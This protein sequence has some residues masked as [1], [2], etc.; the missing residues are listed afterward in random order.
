MLHSEDQD[1]VQVIR[2]ASKNKTVHIA[3]YQDLSSGRRIV[4]W[5]DITIVFRDALYL[6]HGHNVLPFLKGAAFK[7]LEPLR[8]AAVPG[9]VLD[10]VL[11]DDLTQDGGS[12]QEKTQRTYLGTSARLY[13]DE[14]VVSISAATATV[15]KDPQYGEVAAAMENYTYMERPNLSARGPQLFSD[16]QSDRSEKEST[17]DIRSNDTTITDA[18][19]QLFTANVQ[20]ILRAEQPDYSEKSAEWLHESAE[21]GDAQAQFSL[22]LRYALGQGGVA[23]DYSAGM[24]WNI[25]SAKQGFAAAQLAAGVMYEKGTGVAKDQKAAAE[26]YLKAAEQEVTIAQV[27]IGTMYQTGNGVSLDYTAAMEWFL[28]AAERGNLDAMV[29]IGGTYRNGL[30][31]EQ[32]YSLAMEWYLKAA[33]Q[34]HAAAQ[35]NVAAMYA[36]GEG[37]TKN[38][39]TSVEWI[40]KSAEGGHPPSQY[41]LGQ[42]FADG[43]GVLQDFAKAMEWY[44]RAAEQGHADAQFKVGNIYANGLGVRRDYLKAIHWLSKAAKQGSSAAQFRLGCLYEDGLGMSKDRDK[45]KEL[46][47]KAAENGHEGAQRSIL[48]LDPPRIGA[49]PGAVLD[50]VV[51]GDLTQDAGA[52]QEQT[53]TEPLNTTQAIPP[54]AKE[55]PKYGEIE[56]AIENYTRMD[57]PTASARGRNPAYGLVE[58][59]MENYTHIDRPSFTARGPQQVSDANT[60]QS[61]NA[62][63]GQQLS[64]TKIPRAPQLLSATE[65]R[66]AEALAQAKLEEETARNSATFQSLNA[67]DP[68]AARNELAAAQLVKA[69]RCENGNS[70]VSQNYSL[71]AAWFLLAAENGNPEAQYFIGSYYEQGIG[72]SQDYTKASEW[73]FKSAKRRGLNSHAGLNM[74]RLMNKGLFVQPFDGDNGEDDDGDD[75]GEKISLGHHKSRSLSGAFR[76]LFAR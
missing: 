39:S 15:A 44:L 53:Q 60:D 65:L 7:E 43:Y 32:D 58:A 25:K 54:A 51:K 34:G 46:Y 74:S 33:E 73:Y 41:V 42:R 22:A 69:M 31:V 66:F 28:K 64:S 36:V 35:A 3:T 72:V 67:Q 48:S 30:G 23:H 55:D 29:S 27:A 57:P 13:Q 38:E 20:S 21:R 9:A 61:K 8:V 6:Q 2:L 49:I 56:R 50:V 76:K 12:Q 4:L 14:S 26:W 11:K 70:N 18:P 19:R 62:T 63:Q 59:A 1:G 16:T 10:I 5:S 47:L 24:T 37:V 40:R 68:K 17:G 71:A 52:Q 45:A 75:D